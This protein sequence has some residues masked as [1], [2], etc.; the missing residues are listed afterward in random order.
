MDS[1]YLYSKWQ[2]FVNDPVK[3]IF[4]E[5]YLVAGWWQGDGLQ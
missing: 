5:T 1:V 2:A 4:L 3:E